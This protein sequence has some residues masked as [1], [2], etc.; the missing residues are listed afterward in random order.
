[1]LR[2]PTGDAIMRVKVKETTAGPPDIERSK[3]GASQTRVV[4]A[5]SRRGA[6]DGPLGRKADLLVLQHIACEPPAAYED[7][8]AYRGL[9][10]KRVEVDEGES[11][12]DWRE[13]DGLIVMGGP[14]GVNDEAEYPWLREEKALIARAVHAGKPYWGVCLGAQLLAAALGAR[15]YRGAA[16]EVGVYDDVALTPAARSDPVFRAAP[17]RLVCL[18]WHSDT[19]D[20]PEG[21]QALASS[22]AYTQQVFVWNRAYGLQFHLEVPAD[23]ALRWAD[24]PAYTAS[25][26][27]V[28]GP[29]AMPRLVKEIEQ[30]SAMTALARR[31]FGLWLDAIV[32]VDHKE[33]RA[34]APDEGLPAEEPA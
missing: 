27:Q 18:Q 21:A 24:L 32:A 34:S 12:P 6:V 22:P 26:E 4:G 20:L 5:E 10:L 29:G 13:F 2:S 11:L 23:L 31:L 1:M 16:P 8:L 9:S 19:F 15:V 17:A 28:H 33:P 14:M 30:H 3:A 7:E 25:L